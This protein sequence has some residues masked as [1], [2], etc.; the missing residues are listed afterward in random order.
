[1][2]DAFLHRPGRLLNRDV[3]LDLTHGDDAGPFDR[4][5]DLAVSRLRRKLVRAG[6]SQTIETVRGLGYRFIA[7][8][9]LA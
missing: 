1:L 2:L 6:A 7:Q 4:A 3:L 5:V 8:V 9:S